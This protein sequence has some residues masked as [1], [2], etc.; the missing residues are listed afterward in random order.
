MLVILLAGFVWI[1]L[2]AQITNRFVY[3]FY[4]SSCS[5]DEFVAI[6][7]EDRGYQFL[8]LI[9]KDL[10]NKL[11][12]EVSL[13]GQLHIFACLI[14]FYEQDAP[15]ARYY[16]LVPRVAHRDFIYIASLWDDKTG[17]HHGLGLFFGALQF[18]YVNEATS[19]A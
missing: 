13:S 18:Q 15:L 8:I 17:D 4:L 7:I 6:F 14:K 1:L 2:E 16:H 11:L 9:L 3:K 19:L 5:V 12:G 10:R